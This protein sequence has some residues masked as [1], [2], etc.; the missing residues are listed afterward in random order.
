[1]LRSLLV[2]TCLVVALTGCYIGPHSKAV[3]TAMTGAC[4][5]AQLYPCT[6][7]PSAAEKAK[8]SEKQAAAV[9]ATA[10]RDSSSADQD[11]ARRSSC[12]TD[13]GPTLPVNSD[14]CAKYGA[15]GSGNK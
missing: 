14:Q 7:Q 5:A 10:Q 1:M 11:S 12:Q 4:L 6:P 13:T 3:N 9:R 2:G 8:D 15:T